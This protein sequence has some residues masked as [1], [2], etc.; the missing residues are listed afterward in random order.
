V[1]PRSPSFHRRET[2]LAMVVHRRKEMA[3]SFPRSVSLPP[4]PQDR[5]PFLPPM[6]AHRSLFYEDGLLRLRPFSEGELFYMAAIFPSHIAPP[7]PARLPHPLFFPSVLLSVPLFFACVQAS[8]LFV[9]VTSKV[10]SP[11]PVKMFSFP[12]D[13][14][15]LA[16][17]SPPLEASLSRVPSEALRP[18]RPLFSRSDQLPLLP[19]PVKP[20][21]SSLPSVL[22]FIPSLASGWSHHGRL[23]L[24]GPSLFPP[25]SFPSA[26]GRPPAA[27]VVIS[28]SNSV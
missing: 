18:P 17:L 23:P 10:L 24:P 26:L 25:T 13:K 20:F 3:G 11:H 12:P 22:L 28:L 14:K 19:S 1:K 27:R 5:W 16:P 9:R 8:S 15:V 6:E 7:L 2:A 21:L 4:L